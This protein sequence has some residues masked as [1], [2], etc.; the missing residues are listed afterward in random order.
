MDDRLF[1]SLEWRN[2]GPHRGGRCV[3]VAGHPTEAGTFFFGACAGGVFKT[4]NGGSHWR[5]VSD[6]YFNTA[7]VGAISVSDT[8]PN[9]VYAGTGEAC[10]RSNV[11]HGDG[12]YRSDDGGQT[13]RNLGLA[14]TRHISRVVI[15]PTNPDIVYVAALGHAWGPNP[16]R[17]VYRSTNG[18]KTWDLVLHKSDKA[19]AAD[20]TIDFRNPRVLYAAIWHG[21]RFPHA[22]ESGGP[23]SGIWRSL[24]GG[25]TWTEVTRNPGMSSGLLGRIGVAASPAQPGRVWAL[26]EAEDGA[27][28]RSDDYGQTWERLCENADLRR[29]PWYYMHIYADPE[30]QNTVWDLNL[31]CWR[32]VD[33]GK[34]FDAIPTPH[35]DNHG[36]WIDPRNS[37]RMIEGNDG[38]ATV[39]FDGGRT[40][41]SLLNQPTAQFYHV[42]TDN[43]VPYR[44]YG[45]QQ[46][47]WAMSVP[48]MSFEGAISW[49]DYVEPGG[50]ESGYIA[51]SKK[52]PYT[53]FG[54]GIGTGAGHGRLIAW[55]PETGQKRN[56]TVWPEV[57]GM[58]GG[59]DLMKYRF[60]WTFPVETS[61]HDDSTVYICSNYVHRST[62]NGS[63]WETISP[64]LTRNDAEKIGPSGGPITADNS[65]AEIYCTIFAFRESPHERGVFW[66]GSDDGLLH[67]SRDGAKSWQ[68]ITPADLPEWSMINMIE[69]SPHEAATAY[70]A[71]TGYKSDDLRPYLYRTND[72]GATWTRIVNGVP[73]D[74][75]TRVVREDPNKRGLLYCG[76]ERG[77]L[78]SFDD[79][80]NW[81]RLETNLP[82]TPIWDLVVKD[83][84]LVVATHG[85]AFWILDDITPLHQLQS[86]M[87]VK[88]A[89][90]LKPRDTVR[91]RF[92]GRAQGKSKVH[93]NYKMTGPVTVA[94]RRTET[95]QGGI[96]EQFLDAGRNPPDGVIIH[97]WLREP[98]DSVRLSILDADGN[99]VR[100]F[101]PKREM[102][103]ASTPS[104]TSASAPSSTVTSTSSSTP[105]STSSTDS[106][107]S[108]SSTSEGSGTGAEVQQVTASEEVTEPSDDEDAEQAP[109]APNVAGMN[110]FVWDYRYPKPAKIEG[111][112]RGS[113]E[114]AL[115][116]VGGPRAVPG[117][118]QVR[119]SVGDVVQTESFQVLPDPRLPVSLEDL[120]AQFELKVRIRDRTSETNTAV[121]QIRGLR[122]QVESWEKRAAGRKSLLDAAAAVKTELRAIEAELINIDFEKPRPGPNRIKEKLDSLSSMIDESDDAPTR[123]A[124][125]VYDMLAAQLATQQNRLRALLDGQ[126][127]AFNRLVQSEALPAIGL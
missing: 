45:S 16:E 64:D 102:P 3:A 95:P 109:F 82:V 22:A 101:T 73:E 32:S 27:M 21:R 81:Q 30:D 54:G 56:V 106:A 104:G 79:G 117:S 84:D 66:A 94:F 83:T 115:E 96:Q 57:F 20:L 75:F 46:D 11:S 71:A 108:A 43:R 122:S 47:N 107:S 23:D 98:S 34:T 91:F 36:L 61:P 92:Y 65:G 105:S 114:E 60:Q 118:Y 116:N 67:I 77:I 72:Y 37:N 99:E 119:L 121:N 1:R 70:V 58:G 85:R 80:V 87:V 110:R 42:T 53:V 29:R 52:P 111:G 88:P 24:D 103:M 38:G 7:A 93:T 127:A 68:N 126:V 39:T 74:E 90:L 19:G 10:I 89:Q 13:W 50:G 8:D 76:T 40:W 59:A 44:V 14:P 28:F 26:V 51:I 63:S 113:R 62:D 49:R 17:G 100:T 9:V 124:Y 12:V 125:E 41:S 78:I 69:P 97:Y 35:G 15:H 112:S 2:I 120:R 48:S 5:N 25:D 18:G 4:T 123:G 86:D 33:G 31:E 6:G 55:N